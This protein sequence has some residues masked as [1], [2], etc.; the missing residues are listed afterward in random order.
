MVVNRMPCMLWRNANVTSSPLISLPLLKEL[1]YVLTGVQ[2]PT[3]GIGLKMEHA[4]AIWLISVEIWGWR[5]ERG[6]LRRRCNLSPPSFSTFAQKCMASPDHVAVALVWT[7]GE[8]LD[9]SDK[10]L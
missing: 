7:D 10:P 9:A 8:L 6:M 4:A 1:H 3:L 5:T 2:G